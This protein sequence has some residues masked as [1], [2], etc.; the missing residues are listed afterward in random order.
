M[1]FELELNPTVLSTTS[2]HK[3]HRQCT[4]SSVN[5]GLAISREGKT[6]KSRQGTSLV[7]LEGVKTNKQHLLMLP[8]I[9]ES[10]IDGKGQAA[11]A[12]FATPS[13]RIDSTFTSHQCGAMM[14]RRSPALFLEK[15]RVS[16]TRFLVHDQQKHALFCRR[17]EF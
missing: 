8:L 6:V 3:V 15:L 12:R 14:H 5:V 13:T 2:W 4:S 9:I 10:V 17:Y 16:A 1:S 7:S 11:A